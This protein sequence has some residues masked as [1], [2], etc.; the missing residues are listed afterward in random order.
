[1]VTRVV[2]VVL[3][4]VAALGAWRVATFALGFNDEL[5]LQDP[6]I[7]R[8]QPAIVDPRAPRLSQRVIIVMVDGLRLD[9]S[10]QA[11]FDA[12]RCVGNDGAAAS[13]YPT[14]SR[15]NYITLLTGVPP[16]ASGIRHN[17]VRKPMRIDSIM[18]RAKAAGL[19]VTTASDLG[20]VPPL[21][22]TTEV[23]EL[24]GFEHPQTGDLITPAAGR[25]RSTKCARQ[26]RS[27]RSSSRSPQCCRSRATS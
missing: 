23:A 14:V 27:P 2:A 17:R 10:R 15:P 16:I 6:A 13:H 20:M 5:Q 7:A 3:A 24:G 12:V 4:L 11:G 1:M 21:F 25:G 18:T 26:R 19:R 8:S 22:I 9:H